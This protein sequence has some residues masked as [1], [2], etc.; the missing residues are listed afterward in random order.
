MKPQPI[1]FVSG[2]D[3]G[4]IAWAQAATKRADA[5]H[6]KG[7][8]LPGDESANCCRGSDVGWAWAHLQNRTRTVSRISSAHNLGRR[9]Q[10]TSVDRQ[11]PV[12]ATEGGLKPTLQV[13][14]TTKSRAGSKPHKGKL[15]A[16]RYNGESPQRQAGS[17]PLQR[18]IPTKASWKL[19]ATITT[20]S[21]KGKLE[22][23][24]SNGQPLFQK[25]SSNQDSCD[26]LKTK[27]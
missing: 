21:F 18:R 26:E 23:R 11:E 4:W 1:S 27:N 2:S 15:E 6:H 10:M 8:E 14:E 12:K 7:G 16:C 5:L 9:R 19:A 13:R 3:V 25:H 17:S 24:R 22:A 20:L